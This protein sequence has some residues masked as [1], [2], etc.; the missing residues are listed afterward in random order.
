VSQPV[1]QQQQDGEAPTSTRIRVV[2]AEGAYLMREALDRVV[3]GL[4]GIEVVGFCSD[5]DSLMQAVERERPDVILTDIR[6]PST[7]AD[8]GIQVARSLHQ[9]HPEIGVVV[10]SQWSDS[11]CVLGWLQFGSARRAYLLTEGVTDPEQ[12]SAAIR[13][14]VAGGSV[15]DPE[16]LELLDRARSAETK[17]RLAELTPREHDVLAGMAQ[18]KSNA[19]IAQSLAL[20]KRAVEKY[21]NGIFTKME[22]AS[23]HDVSRRVKATLLFLA[24][25]EAQPHE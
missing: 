6:L 13:T 21:I 18:G 2:I 17:S 10:L 23:P 14:V 5:R 1:V 9:T 19:A 24:S 25:G 16:V 11:S 3:G 22:L 4:E 12:L 20:T 8:E 15:I 7:G